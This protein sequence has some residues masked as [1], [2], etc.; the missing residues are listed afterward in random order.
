M[1]QLCWQ[2]LDWPAAV[3]KQGTRTLLNL[4]AVAFGGSHH[5]TVDRAVLA[6]SAA[7]RASFHLTPFLIVDDSSLTIFSLG[8]RR[9]MSIIA[10][11]H[12]LP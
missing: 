6:A 4:V 3:R 9:G 11:A 12:L 10:L 8:R 5:E 7:L 2:Q 1:C